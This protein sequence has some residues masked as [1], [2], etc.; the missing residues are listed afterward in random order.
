MA[1]LNSFMKIIKMKKCKNVIRCINLVFTDFEC[2]FTYFPSIFK[3]NKSYLTKLKCITTN[4]NHFIL[5][6]LLK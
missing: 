2:L 3:T 1:Y 4:L 6:H 5:K